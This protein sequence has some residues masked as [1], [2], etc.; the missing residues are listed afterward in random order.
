MLNFMPH[1]KFH[2]IWGVDKNCSPKETET[3][4]V[5]RG[6]LICRCNRPLLRVPYCARNFESTCNCKSL[7]L[8]SQNSESFDLHCIPNGLFLTKRQGECNDRFAVLGTG[9]MFF[10]LG[11]G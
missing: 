8:L 9:Y 2:A 1:A 11:T 6:K 3:I 5:T 7:R 10:A 4:Y